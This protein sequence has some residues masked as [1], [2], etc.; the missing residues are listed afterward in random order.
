MHGACVSERL[1]RRAAKGRNPETLHGSRHLGRNACKAVKGRERVSAGTH[2]AQSR[3]CRA[4]YH[5]PKCRPYAHKLPG[6]QEVRGVLPAC[7]HHAHSSKSH[8]ARRPMTTC[9]SPARSRVC[10]AQTE[11]TAAVP[12]ASR[13]Y[14]GSGSGRMPVRGRCCPLPG[15]ALQTNT[16]IWTLALPWGRASA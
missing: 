4:P 3:S 12:G 11:R 5:P 6:S 1:S 2:P 14:G 15:R 13:R 9:C 16:D 7:L 10:I 8:R